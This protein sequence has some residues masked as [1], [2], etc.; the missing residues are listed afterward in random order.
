VLRL[1]TGGFLFAPDVR[2]H[3][4]PYYFDCDDLSR[5]PEIGKNRSDLAKK[6]FDCMER[7]SPTVP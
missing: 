5:L 7:S 3:S 1:E 2:M 6:F 4:R